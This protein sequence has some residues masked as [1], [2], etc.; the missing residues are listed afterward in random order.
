MSGTTAGEPASAGAN[1]ALTPRQPRP[2]RSTPDGVRERGYSPSMREIGRAVGLT[3]PSSVEHQLPAWE[4]RGHLR[5]EAGCPRRV[6]ARLPGVPP[7]P[8]KGA[9]GA[10]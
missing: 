8:P 2:L 9:E 5:G 3:S 1:R 10:E 7:V 6:E 4:S